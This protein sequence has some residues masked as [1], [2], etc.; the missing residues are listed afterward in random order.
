MKT[1]SM[2]LSRFR[3]VAMVVSLSL[4]LTFPGNFV[5][6]Q[7]SQEPPVAEEAE[8]EPPPRPNVILEVEVRGNQVI[9]TGVVLNQMKIRKGG[10]LVQEDVNEDIK[11]LYKTGYFRDI[12]MEVE[13]EPEGYRLIV[14][15]DE[16]PIVRQVILDGFATFKEADLRKELKILEGQILDERALKEGIEAIR[17]KYRSKGFRFIEV[18]SELDINEKTREATILI[19]ILEGE[20]YKIKEIHLQGVK[21]FKLKKIRKLM[22]TKKDT[23]FTS[24]VFNEEK[25]QKDLDRV[26]LFYQQEGYLDVK[27]APEFEYDRQNRKIIITVQIEEGTHYVTGEIKIEGAVLFPESEIWQ[28]LEMLPGTTYSQYYLA[29]DMDQIRKYYFER[30]YVDARVVPDV[31]LNRETAKV[32]V[33]YKIH[34][35][36]LY[37]VDKV[38][39]QGNTKTKDIVI[40]RELRIRPGDRFDGEKIQKS[41]QRLE[42]LDFFEEVTYDMEPGSATNRKDLIFR[43]KEKRTGELSFGGGVSS[44]D[45]FVGFGEISQ[46][47]FDLLSFPRFTGAGQRLSVKARVGTISQ[48][49]EVSFVEPYLLG[50]KISLGVDGFNTRRDNRNVDFDENRL[51]FGVTIAKMFG[52]VF[53]LGTGYVLE[54][55]KLEDISDDAPQIVLD[56]EGSTTLSRA[57][58]FQTWDTRDN[59]FNPSKGFLV[60]FQ[61]ELVGSFI[62]GDEDFYVLQGSYSQY[63]TLFKKHVVEF[64][65]RLGTAD[66]FGDSD[67]VPVFDRFYAGGLGTVRGYNY[68]RVGPIEAGDAVG[69][70]TIAIVSLEYTFPIPYIEIIKGA[71]FID[72]GEVD[73]DSYSIDFGDFA[74]SVGPGIKIKTP[75]GPF[76]FY[77][78]LPIANKDTEDRNGRFEFSLSHG[79]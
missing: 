31:Q 7:E 22:K 67:H 37:F 11:R 18:E 19:H 58:L 46:K 65:L 75:I 49:Y 43:I 9:S 45:K 62:G 57:R 15:V 47:N 69:G 44:I 21:A 56:S 78:G 3:L 40:R 72:I 63:V 30:G 68:R 36:D 66:P 41:V 17:K 53:R 35:G 24:G 77:Y 1:P 16:K 10:P 71:A 50:R 52:D 38:I 14:F 32:D 27:V 73:P 79:F 64:K 20:K 39:V 12:R 61:E 5:W 54:R 4:I 26:Q 48:N 28:S 34:E 29:N 2:V 23:L 60:S 51:G 59:I 8:P 76:A 70:Q 13:E 6:P 25:F 55:V 74:I 42:N 33:R